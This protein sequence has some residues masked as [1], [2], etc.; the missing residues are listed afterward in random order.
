M[1]FAMG[2]AIGA[3]LAAPERKV[4][5][6]LGDGGFA[7]SGMELLTAVRE[8]VSLMVIVLNDGQLGRIRC[9]QLSAYG[10][11]SSVKLLN[12][13]F[14]GV[15]TGLGAKYAY[16]D[17]NP[18]SVIERAGAHTGVS[19][20]EVPVRDTGEIHALRVRGLMRSSARRVLPKA[21]VSTIKRA[22]SPSSR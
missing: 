13:D 17:D 5:A 16:C 22:L 15:A 6:V 1:G 8:N 4:V 9:E 3:K 11:T 12:P 14:R 21:L 20:I 18:A 19:V 7:M 2:A 10:R